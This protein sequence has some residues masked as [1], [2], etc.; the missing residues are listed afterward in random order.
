MAKK[1]PL[2]HPHIRESLQGLAVPIEILVPDPRNARRHDTKNLDAVRESLT[3][4]GQMLPLVVQ[5]QGMIVR[6]GNGRLQAAKQLGW[7]HMA[8]VVTEMTDDEAIAFAI[9]DNRTSELASWDDE[10]L[11]E[12]LTKL[13]EG[14]SDLASLGFDADD[15]AA[16][17]IGTASDTPSLDDALDKLDLTELEPGLDIRTPTVLT[18]GRFQLILDEGEAIELEAKI[19]AFVRKTGSTDGFV[20][21]RVLTAR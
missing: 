19:E 4:H 15:L 17:S 7:S 2:R 20:R 18:V 6:A 9:A 16:L 8:C 5:K 3:T 14:G 13:V 10:V 21:E 12:E 11:A 1:A